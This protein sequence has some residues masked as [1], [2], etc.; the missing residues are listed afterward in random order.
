MSELTF[1]KKQIGPLME[2]YGIKESDKAFSTIISMFKDQTNYQIW[3]IKMVYGGSCNIDTLK[4]VAEFAI[5]HQPEIKNLQKGNIVSYKTSAE[6]QILLQEIEGT[7]NLLFLRGWVNA[8]NTEQK[9]MLRSIL[10]LESIK[11]LSAANSITIKSWVETFKMLSLLPKHKRD[12]MISLASAINNPDALKAHII[13]A[14]KESYDWEHDDMIAYLHNNASDCEVVFD[15]DNVVVITVPSFESSRRMCGK[16]RTSWCITRDKKYFEQYC[17]EPKNAHQY[18]LF[19]FNYP[20]Y[21]D[22]AH[23]GF[24]VRDGEGITNAHSTTN[25]SLTSCI[26]I[27]G[28]DVNIHDALRMANVPKDIYVKLRALK[29]YEWSTESILKFLNDHKND[30]KV[31]LCKDGKLIVEVLNN[32]GGRHIAMHSFVRT[33]SIDFSREDNK[34]FVYFNTQLPYQD[35]NALYFICFNKDKYSTY[36]LG[37]ILDAYNINKSSSNILSKLGLTIRNFIDVSNIDPSILLHKYIDNK[38]E[39]DAIELLA[40]EGDKVDVNKTL[41]NYAPIFN[42]IQNKMVRLFEVLVTNKKF[43]FNV[44]TNFNETIYDKLLGEYKLN[45]VTTSEDDAITEHMIDIMLNSGKCDLNITNTNDDTPVNIACERPEL[46]WVA[47]RLIENPSV[48][49]NVVNDFNC[50]A[51]G[52]AIRKKNIEAIK[53]LATRPDLVVRVEDKELAACSKVNLAKYL[54]KDKLDMAPEPTREMSTTDLY[55]ELFARV[56]A[57]SMTLMGQQ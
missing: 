48:N 7:E 9:N 40:K 34:W 11:P 53:L 26:R 43:N 31:V 3:A 18:M 15:K 47:K 51:L 30:F 1:S 28:K 42:V 32:N 21:H 5:L 24:T 50:T 25:N 8:F 55:T 12:K 33:D 16:G 13:D 14:T 27:D 22:L 38:L 37:N 44:K 46:L 20:E 57:R 2:R 41:D 17:I 54:P 10:N 19:N 56:F 4:K 39:S 35:D 6:V 52:N 23:I 29:G 36:T 49:I 45:G